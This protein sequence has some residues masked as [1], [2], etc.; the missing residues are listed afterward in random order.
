FVTTAV[1]PLI[2][3]TVFYAVV[4][5]VT[6]IASRQNT[7]YTPKKKKTFLVLASTL[8]FAGCVALAGFRYDM[9]FNVVSVAG[10]IIIFILLYNT[11]RAKITS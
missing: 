8:F 2:L 9:I 1:S 6:L 7:S 3:F 10:C 11:L 4:C 5:A